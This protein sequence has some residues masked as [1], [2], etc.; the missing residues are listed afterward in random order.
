M[1]YSNE[2]EDNPGM[3]IECLLRLNDLGYKYR[4]GLIKEREKYNELLKNRLDTTRIIMDKTTKSNLV[5]LVLKFEVDL[6]QWANYQQ[7]LIL[8]LL[9]HL[10]H[11]LNLY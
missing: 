11:Y 6:L 4:D 3:F 8:V 2:Q 10:Q 9:R 1:I 7:P 5:D